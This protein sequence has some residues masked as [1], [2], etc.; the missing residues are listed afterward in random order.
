MPTT[1]CHEHWHHISSREGFEGTWLNNPKHNQH[2]PKICSGQTVFET[3]VPKDHTNSTP[4]EQCSVNVRL[5]VSVS[6]I[7]LTRIAELAL[8]SHNIQHEHDSVR[9]SHKPGLLCG[10]SSRSTSSGRTSAARTTGGGLLELD[11]AKRRRSRSRSRAFA[12]RTA[13]LLASTSAWD[14]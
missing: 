13:F 14:R 3:N 4:C 12:I 6:G 9:A 1:T 11:T 5:V 7:R 8:D 2:E 10:G